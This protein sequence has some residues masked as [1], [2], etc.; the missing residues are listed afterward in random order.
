[1]NPNTIL[2]LLLLIFALILSLGFIL[3]FFRMKIGEMFTFGGGVLALFLS[4]L[5]IYGIYYLNS[6]YKDPS[7]HLSVFILSIILL[8]AFLVLFLVGTVSMFLSTVDHEN[9]KRGC[10]EPEIGVFATISLIGTLLC[11]VGG[12]YFFEPEKVCDF[13]RMLSVS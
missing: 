4:V 5:C 12:L 7:Y 8:G 1:M 10:D 3:M 6:S 13:I 9:A 11:S 2:A